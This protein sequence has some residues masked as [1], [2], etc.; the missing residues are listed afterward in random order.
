VIDLLKNDPF[1]VGMIVAV[2]VLTY[3]FKLLM[4]LTFF[5]L[6]E[7]KTSVDNNTNCVKDVDNSVKNLKEEIRVNSAHYDISFAEKIAKKVKGEFNDV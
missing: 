1:L 2:L 3:P 5:K 4:Q 7:M 6:R